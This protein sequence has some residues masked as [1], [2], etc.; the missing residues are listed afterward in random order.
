MIT[1]FL[2]AAA[3]MT[4]VYRLCFRWHGH[5][6]SENSGKDISVLFAAQI[7]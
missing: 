3:A 1:Y 7:T 4:S 2:S 5:I 6:L